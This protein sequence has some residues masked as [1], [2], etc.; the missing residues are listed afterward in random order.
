MAEEFYRTGD[1]GHES[2]IYPILNGYQ[3]ESLAKWFDFLAILRKEINPIFVDFIKQGAPV[4][5]PG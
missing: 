4:K 1:S 3:L 5:C 2:C